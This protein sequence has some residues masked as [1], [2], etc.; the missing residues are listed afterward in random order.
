VDDLR[1]FERSDRVV[2]GFRA[3]DPTP[4]VDPIGATPTFTG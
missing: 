2:L 1:D 3:A 4:D